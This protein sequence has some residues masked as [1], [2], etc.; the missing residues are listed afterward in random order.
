MPAVFVHGVPE[1]AAI[2]DPLFKELDRTDLVAI[3][4]PGF[5]APV[6]DGW[7]ATRAEYVAWLDAELVG[8]A[9]RGP[10]D[11]VGH[12]WGA[13]HVVGT[14]IKR[15]N[16]VRSWAVDIM[17]MLHHDYE[18]HDMAQQW[19]TAEVGEAVIA[20]MI[21]TPKPDLAGV[22]QSLGMSAEGALASVTGLD[23]AMGACILSLVRDAAQPV[24]ADLGA[25][26]AA[27]AARPGLVLAPADDDYDGTLAMSSEVAGRAGAQVAELANV[28]HWWMMQDPAAAALTLEEF[29]ASSG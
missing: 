4:P 23:E 16:I 13:A 2:W 27:M 20:G 14:L 15:P 9:E 22:F 10:I 1:V 8:L 18:W 3:S 6:P 12:D 5:G 11:L 21:A 26:V 25:Q 29:W 19:Q 28:G 24:M 17:G 7:T